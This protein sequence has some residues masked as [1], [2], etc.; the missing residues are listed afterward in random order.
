MPFWFEVALAA[1]GASDQGLL[2]AFAR[3]H[4]FS[5]DNIGGRGRLR[6]PEIVMQ[7]VRPLSSIQFI[8]G[9]LTPVNNLSPV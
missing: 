4:G 1:S 3:F 5:N 9:V 8:A 6:Q 2:G 7:Q